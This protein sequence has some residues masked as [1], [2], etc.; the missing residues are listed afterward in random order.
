MI[1]ATATGQSPEEDA[2]PR[3]FQ[4]LSRAIE[5]FAARLASR[6]TLNQADATRLHL[7]RAELSVIRHIEEAV[8]YFAQA[9]E[10]QGD[11]P[12]LSETL[13]E[14]LSLCHPRRRNRTQRSDPG[15]SR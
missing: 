4:D 7:L 11:Q 14:L 15:T 8:R 13:E 9:L 5:E 3:A 10:R 1:H 2:P 6:S 12:T